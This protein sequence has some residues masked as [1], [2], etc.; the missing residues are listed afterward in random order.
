MRCGITIA[1]VKRMQARWDKGSVSDG[2]LCF[3]EAAGDQARKTDT[4]SRELQLAGAACAPL[5][6]AP[7]DFPPFLS[8]VAVGFSPGVTLEIRST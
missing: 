8:F 3:V 5:L 6:A 1:Q 4:D 2:G 7:F